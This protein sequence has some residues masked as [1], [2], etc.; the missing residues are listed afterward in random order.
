MC[1][2]SREKKFN[3]FC[4]KIVYMRFFFWSALGRGKEFD[5]MCVCVRDETKSIHLKIIKQFLINVW[6][7]QK[8]S[9]QTKIYI[10]R[11]RGVWFKY[12]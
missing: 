7:R 3:S 9:F 10:L 1:A 11:L 8:K 12:E 4:G 2:L 6:V 5:D